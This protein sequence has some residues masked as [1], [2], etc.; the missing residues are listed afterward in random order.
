MILHRNN[1]LTDYE[2]A[3]ELDIQLITNSFLK[4]QLF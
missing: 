1:K 2:E 3:I 4:V